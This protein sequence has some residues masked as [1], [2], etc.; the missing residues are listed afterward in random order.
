MAVILPIHQLVARRPVGMGFTNRSAIE[1]MIQRIANI[2]MM[3][4]SG[5][6][7][8]F[9]HEISF[10]GIASRRRTFPIGQCDTGDRTESAEH[11]ELSRDHIKILRAARFRIECDVLRMLNDDPIA[12]LNAEGEFAKRRGA[13]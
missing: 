1:A 5:F 10:V 9:L 2:P 8:I 7:L 11:P 4:F 6:I 3:S 12:V 13:D